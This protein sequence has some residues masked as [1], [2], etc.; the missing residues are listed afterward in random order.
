MLNTIK[1]I[2]TIDLCLVEPLKVE[3]SKVELS[4]IVTCVIATLVLFSLS[5]VVSAAPLNSKQRNVVVAASLAAPQIE[6]TAWALMEVNSGWVVAGSNARKPLPPASITKLM[7]NYVVF[8]RLKS[9]DLKMTDQ[10]PIS[11][12][13]WRSEGSR[14]F[15]DV[16]SKV[17]L[18]HLLKSTIIQSGNDAAVAL[19]EFTA[20]SELGFAQ[21]MNQAGI[22]LGLQD[23]HYANSSGLP[24]AG[25]VMSASD[26]AALSAAIISEFPE[27]YK[28][29]AEK[30]YTHNDITQYNRNKLLWK[31]GSVDG[32]KT[33]HTNEAGYC[34]VGSALRG[35]QRWIA[36]VLGSENE[37][38]RESQVLS[39]L[40]YGF[41]AYKALKLL[42]EQGGLASAPVYGGEVDE[43]RLQVAKAVSIVVPSGREDDVV[44]DLRYSPYFE[45]PIKVGQAM[46]VA[47]LSLDGK[48][49]MDVPLISMSAIKKGGLWKQLSD[50]AKLWFKGLL[51]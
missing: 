51:S 11:E 21:M 46:G 27:F 1:R 9:G 31:D 28:W 38:V 47:S 43:V 45:A 44:T 20:G 14:M 26:I 48:V 34:L 35:N 41:A 8:A 36:V 7:M 3:P 42:D 19:A 29:Y 49:L 50:A 32:L 33:G 30:A 2:A 18:G 16:N 24:A 10:V 23:S 5:A 25:H 37:R 40:N 13:A 15:A 39:L 12:R 4:R 22:N 6:A 17:E